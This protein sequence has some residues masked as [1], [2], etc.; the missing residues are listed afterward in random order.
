[1]FRVSGLVADHKEALEAPPS[2]TL[3]F[4]EVPVEKVWQLESYTNNWVKLDCVCWNGIHSPEH[5]C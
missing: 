1:M 2:R 3:S 4:K 5:Q